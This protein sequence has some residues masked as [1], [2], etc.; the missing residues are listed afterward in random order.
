[1]QFPTPS[2]DINGNAIQ[3]V[4]EPNSQIDSIDL[5]Q[6]SELLAVSLSNI[7]AEKFSSEDTLQYTWSPSISSACNTYS[8]VS[9]SLIIESGISNKIGASL[10]GAIV[11]LTFAVSDINLRLIFI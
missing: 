4:K 10:I 5:N 11:I 1:M 8:K 2:D 9:P 7:F 6:T 3:I